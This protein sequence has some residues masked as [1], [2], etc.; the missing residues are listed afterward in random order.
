M[1]IFLAG[2]TGYLGSYYKKYLEQNKIKHFCI[3]RYITSSKNILINFLKI[4]INQEKKPFY[5]INAAGFS[6]K[7]NVDGCEDHKRECLESNVILP[8]LLSEVCQELNIIL[9]HISSGCVYN[10]YDKI[11][12]EN[13]SSNFNFRANNCSWYSGTKALAEEL[14]ENNE[15]SY[16]LRLR[17]PFDFDLDS[18]RNYLRKLI[19]YSK[20]VDSLNSI[21]NIQDFTNVTFDI[22]NKNLPFGKYNIFNEQPVQTKEVISILTKHLNLE[23]KE[24][25]ENIEEFQKTVKAKRTNCVL[26]TEKLKSF[27]I[28]LDNAYNSIEKSILIYKK[29]QNEDI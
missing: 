17:F 28:V 21:T 29:K 12:T 11:W 7:P 10:G 15:K 9:V 27:G 20:I 3:G 24:W 22:I 23:K 14:L 1:T 19:N 25:F 2:S 13:D 16:I 26:S 18:S 4:H 6:G 5:L 8:S